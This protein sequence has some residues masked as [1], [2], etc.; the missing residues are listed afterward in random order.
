MTSE[1]NKD[2]EKENTKTTVHTPSNKDLSTNEKLSKN[3]I[4]NARK[5]RLVN[6][7]F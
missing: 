6:I 5:N 1:M 7:I 2:K 4:K 3:D